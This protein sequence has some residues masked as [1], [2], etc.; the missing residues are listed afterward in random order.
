MAILAI[1]LKFYDKPY[2]M[3]TDLEDIYQEQEAVPITKRELPKAPPPPA[4]EVIHVVNNSVELDEELDIAITETDQMDVVDWSPSEEVVAV[5]SEEEEPDEILNFAVVE[6]VPVFPGC[7]WAKDNEARKVCFQEKI[8]QFVKE[9]FKYPSVAREMNIQGRFY[10][11]FVVEKDGNISNIN[12]VR[13]VDPLLDN[14]AIRVVKALPKI[15][16]AR[17][18]G[19]PVRMSFVLPINAVMKNR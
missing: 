3:S 8:L 15:E 13:G 17:Q 4:P 19:K 11:Q 5:D 9:E 18:R 6:S 2:E 16:P 7:E 10:I 12:V 14:E 1:N